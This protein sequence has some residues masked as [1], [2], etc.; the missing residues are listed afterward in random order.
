MNEAWQFL[1]TSSMVL[2]AI[3]GMVGIT[4]WLTPSYGG[5]EHD[6]RWLSEA[7]QCTQCRNK[8][9]HTDIADQYACHVC[10]P[11]KELCGGDCPV[12]CQG[13]ARPGSSYLGVGPSCRHGRVVIDKGGTRVRLPVPRQGDRKDHPVLDARQTRKSLWASPHHARHTGLPAVCTGAMAE[14][15]ELGKFQCTIAPVH[16]LPPAI[17]S[18]CS[19][20]DTHAVG[21]PWQVH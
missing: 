15:P 4:W 11:K 18:A 21:P 17:L 13:Q 20:C 10:N 16:D 5:S 2:L 9:R 3:I 7:M 8:H 19:F 6:H 1:G 12:V 14:A